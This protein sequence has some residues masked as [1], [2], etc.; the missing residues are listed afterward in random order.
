MDMKL[1]IAELH[2][3][4]SKKDK[5]INKIKVEHPNLLIILSPIAS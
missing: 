1:S 5:N 2:G 4:R 3:K